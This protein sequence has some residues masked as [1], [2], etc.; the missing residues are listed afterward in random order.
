M[1]KSIFEFGDKFGVESPFGD[2]MGEEMTTSKEIKSPKEFGNWNSKSEG[3][4]ITKVVSVNLNSQ[5]LTKKIESEQGLYLFTALTSE[6]KKI[7]ESSEFNYKHQTLAKNAIFKINNVQQHI[8]NFSE[9]INVNSN[10]D[11]LS[12]AM[13]VYTLSEI[14][15]FIREA[16]S[17]VSSRYDGFPDIAKFRHFGHKCT[18]DWKHHYGGGYTFVYIDGVGVFETNFVGN[19]FYGRIASVLG[20]KLSRTLYDGDWYQKKLPVSG[21]YWKTLDGIDDPLDSYA[22]ALGGLFIGGLDENTFKRIK[23][24]KKDVKADWTAWD[25]FNTASYEI[26]YYDYYHNDNEKTESVF[27][28]SYKVD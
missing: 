26:E 9:I 16:I 8:R 17:F 13:K 28:T 7:I 4:E 20:Q 3:N 14:N 1:K 21:L 2:W 5:G 10:L 27:K 12:K 15:K 23:T 25:D 19:I 6:G 18:F 24:F 22:L 11:L